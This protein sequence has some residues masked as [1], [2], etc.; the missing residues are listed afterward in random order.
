MHST[1]VSILLF[2]SLAF[3]E[4]ENKA[5]APLSNSFETRS[6]VIANRFDSLFSRLAERRGFNGNVLV[7]IHGKVVYKNSFGYSNLKTKKPLNAKSVFQIASV[8]KQFT[9]AAIMMLKEQG[10]LDY[11]DTIQK[12]IPD[13]PYKNITIRHLLAHRSGLPN[14]MYFSRNKLIFSFLVLVVNLQ[15]YAGEFSVVAG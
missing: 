11:D 6:A 8:T 2:A 5:P 7:G 4:G 14:Y 9:A 13:F 12:Y 1:I 3:C 15:L 10:R